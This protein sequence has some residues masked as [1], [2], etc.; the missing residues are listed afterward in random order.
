MRN[1]LWPNGVELNRF[2]L[3]V[4]RIRFWAVHVYGAKT[5]KVAAEL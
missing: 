1:G 4:C 5:Y 2:R 3:L